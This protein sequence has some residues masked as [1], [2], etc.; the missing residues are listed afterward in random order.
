MLTQGKLSLFAAL[1]VSANN[2]VKGSA[3]RRLIHGCIAVQ[4][5]TTL[6][7]EKIQEKNSP[8]FITDNK[9]DQKIEVLSGAFSR[10]ESQHK[11]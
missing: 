8:D 2:F 1:K 11:K 4:G 10:L 6:S 5:N 7:F 9:P 3:E